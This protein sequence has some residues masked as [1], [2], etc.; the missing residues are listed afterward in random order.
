MDLHQAVVINDLL[1]PAGPPQ[2]PGDLREK[3]H[4]IAPK[5]LQLKSAG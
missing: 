1:L 4:T 3:D 2:L 5:G